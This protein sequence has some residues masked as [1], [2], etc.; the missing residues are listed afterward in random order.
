MNPKTNDGGPAKR[1]K[2]S[3]LGSSLSEAYRDI[4]P[5][6]NISYFF[7]AAIG[8]FAWIGHYLDGRWGSK[9]WG[10]IGGAVLGVIVGFYNFIK[11]VSRSSEKNKKNGQ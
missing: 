6:L 1:S 10:I 8:L 3:S 9:P 7:L 4:S 5:Y 2:R 11:T